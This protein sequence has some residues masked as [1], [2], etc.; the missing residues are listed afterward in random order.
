MAHVIVTSC[1][2]CP[3]YADYMI[4]DDYNRGCYHPDNPETWDNPFES[5]PLKKEPI[6][7]SLD[8]NSQPCQ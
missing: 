2:D 5:C 8:Q 3:L 6:T 1:E 7:I 4:A